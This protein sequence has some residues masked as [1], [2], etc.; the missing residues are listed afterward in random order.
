MVNN[1]RVKN[2]KLLLSVFD[3]KSFAITVLLSCR[4]KKANALY[5]LFRRTLN[6]ITIMHFFPFLRAKSYTRFLRICSSPARR[7]PQ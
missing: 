3:R 1:K 5:I 6:I 7:R 2:R 4:E